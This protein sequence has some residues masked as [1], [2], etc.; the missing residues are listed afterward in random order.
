[1]RSI[2]RGY[3]LPTGWLNVSAMNRHERR[4]LLSVGHRTLKL[5]C[6]SCERVGQPMSKEHF[7]PRWL[8]DHADVHA[9]GIRWLGV[10]GLIHPERATVP[11][12]KQCN[13]T[14]GRELESPVAAIFAR[15]EQDDG[16]TD[17]DAELLVRWMWKFEGMQWALNA[18][19]AHP[20]GRYTGKFTLLQRVTTS[21]AFDE[22]RPDMLLAV[23]MCQH[24][25][26]GFHDWPL[27]LD[28]PPSENAIAMSGVFGRIAIV[29]SLA[30]FSEAIPS[31][32][33]RYAF[34]QPPTNRTTKVFVPPR[35][36]VTANAAVE[37]T[38]VTGLLLAFLHDRLGRQ[39]GAGSTQ[40]PNRPRV[41]LPPM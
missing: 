5:R 10:E 23:A 32:F 13:E 18:A 24:N 7:F 22:V 40:A 38:Q 11:L 3:R 14:L 19:S 39:A 9:E 35:T 15:L 8:I 25:D 37:T 20:D 6:L 1:M 17:E 29:T 21:A 34:G 12:C 28:T 36:F 33:G 26:E 2:P 16:L 4:K 31:A 41:E 27:G 30:Q